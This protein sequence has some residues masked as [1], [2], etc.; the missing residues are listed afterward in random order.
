[1][2]ELYLRSVNEAISEGELALWRDSYNEILACKEAIEESICQNFD[3]SFLDHDCIQPVLHR[4]GADRMSY[5]LANTVRQLS[6]DG[7]FSRENRAWSQD[8]DV[9]QDGSHNAAFVVS[10]HPAV[11][12]GFIHLFREVVKQEQV[13]KNNMTMK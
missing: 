9:V 5:V 8:V 3:G 13:E 1:M 11:L 4:F 10:S 6:W 12:D 7:R 2:S